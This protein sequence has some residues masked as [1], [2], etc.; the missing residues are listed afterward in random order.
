MVAQ[1]GALPLFLGVETAQWSLAD[2]QL[3][4]R[5]AKALGVSSLLVKVAD[6][7]NVWYGD[8]GGWRQVLDTVSDVGLPAIAYT[9]CYGDTYRGLQGEISILLTIMQQRGIAIADMEAEYNGQVAWAQQVTDA[10]KNIPGT[11][12]VT[13]WA[14]PQEQNWSGVLQALAP[15]VNFW[16]PQTYTDYLAA[17]YQDQYRGYSNVYPVLYLGNDLG[18]ND[19][20]QTANN[21]KSPTLGLWEYQ[22]IS[23][24]AEVINALKGGAAM[25]IPQDWHDDGHILTAPNGGQITDGFRD[26]VLGHNWDA[27]NWP[28]MSVQSLSP[29]EQGHASL[30]SGTVQAFRKVI[31]VWT[32]QTGCYE[33]W[34]GQEYIALYQ[35]LHDSLTQLTNAQAQ[36]KALQA[37]L[38][39]TP[40]DATLTDLKNRLN[41][42]AALATQ[43]ATISKI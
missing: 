37:Q 4:A 33:M 21:A 22:S 15:C 20:V 24:W 38:A 35:K 11:F 7:T 25:G 16:M 28:L 1:P 13:T 40:P 12:G 34:A 27:G 30:G 5:S 26:W 18:P 17:H 32:S 3:A 8:I 43:L 29:V 42:T 6:G 36:V 31:L 23:A 39:Q 9:Y 10:L 2:F 19:I 14:N 41:Q